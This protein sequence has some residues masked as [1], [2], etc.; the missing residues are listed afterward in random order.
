MLLSARPPLARLAL[1][2]QAIRAGNWPNASTLARELEVSPRT[3]QRDINFLRDRLQAPLAFDPVR[4]GWH[5][6]C[7]DYHFPLVRITEG[8]LIALFVAERVLRQCKGT[9]FE[10]DLCRATTRLAAMLPETVSLNLA[11]LADTLSVT[12]TAVTV[13]DV[14]IFSQVAGAT[15]ARRQLELDYWTASR[16]SRTRRVVDPY[17]LTLIDGNWFLIGW[18]HLRQCVRMFAMQRIR[19]AH[20]TGQSFERPPDFRIEDFLRGS[21]R[22][23]RGDGWHEVVLRFSPVVARRVAEKSWHRSQTTKMF[24]DGT[25]QLR[26]E[27]SDLR[28]VMRWVLSWGRECTVEA[29]VLLRKLVG[30]ELAALKYLY[31]R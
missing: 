20:P 23:F 30:E 21:F 24:A 22:A 2:D 18:C 3:V 6:T 10:A 11:S 28:E 4:H 13:Q 12:P 27:V 1:I 5:Y 29:P 8:E 17:H 19:A 9:P 25:L 7:P 26:L 14:A 15:T 31:R 16:N